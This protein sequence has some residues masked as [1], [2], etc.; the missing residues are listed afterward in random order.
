MSEYDFEA[1]ERLLKR[2]EGDKPKRG[3]GSAESS[4]DEG[5]GFLTS[6]AR[7]AAKEGASLLTGTGNLANKAIG[8]VSPS[9]RDLLSERASQSP[10]IQRMQQ[11]GSEP[12]QNVGE[13]VGGIG[14]DI[15][16]GFA[17][18]TGWIGR[19][20]TSVLG[21]ILPARTIRWAA[22]VAAKATTEAAA[23][24]AKAASHIPEEDIGKVFSDIEFDKT[25]EAAEAAASRT[26]KYA[27]RFKP[28]FE[29]G[30][31]GFRAEPKRAYT[32]RAT[33]GAAKAG[34]EEA[35][36][37]TSTVPKAAPTYETR[38]MQLPSRWASRIGMPAGKI[39]G[40][41]AMGGA[42]SDQDDP[43]RGAAYGAIG[44]AVPS[45]IGRGVISP[46]GRYAARHLLPTLGSMAGYMGLHSLGLP[47]WLAHGLTVPNIRWHSSPIGKRLSRLG[48]RIVDQFGNLVGVI[49]GAPSGIAAGRVSQGLGTED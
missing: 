1:N 39:L 14:T 10:D 34:A 36:K 21:R 2:L 19:A 9:T 38:T 6:V 22:P 37:T 12:Y 20:V 27:G 7:G 24:T 15:G 8:L 44:G 3:S 32:N 48:D 25:A 28:V 47:G 35:G 42:I 31:K 16:T 45:V 13:Y 4:E 26:P 46:V 5:P 43:V 29:G 41:G 40:G 49:E 33:P 11:F 18:P 30:G 17:I 23:P